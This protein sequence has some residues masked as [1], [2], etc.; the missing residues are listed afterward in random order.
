[1]KESTLTIKYINNDYGIQTAANDELFCY[2]TKDLKHALKNN[3][4][5]KIFIA[6]GINIKTA[7]KLAFKH[8]AIVYLN[9][10]LHYDFSKLKAKKET[11]LNNLLKILSIAHEPVLL[12]NAIEILFDNLKHQIPSK[13][14][15]KSA[16]QLVE[17]HISTELNITSSLNKFK[18]LYKEH[19]NKVKK[20]IK[21]APNE[22]IVKVK[23]SYKNELLDFIKNTQGISV[24]VGGMGSGKS[25]YCI[26]PYFNYLCLI[27]DYQP[28]LITPDIA[29]SKQIIAESDPRHYLNKQNGKSP[30][31]QDC[32]RLN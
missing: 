20:Y 15:L 13:M 29:L 28:T 27:E 10:T 30:L 2:K 23:L 5:N 31:C 26:T 18:A 14:P 8:G 19:Q 3:S 7:I 25:L 6:T 21:P 17:R 32:C 4:S 11:N 22:K 1:M 24:L 16:L 9:S 12:S